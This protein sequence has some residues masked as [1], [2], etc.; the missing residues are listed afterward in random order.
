MVSIVFGGV[1]NPNG[2]LTNWNSFQSSL[3]Y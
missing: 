2:I 3:S 1:K